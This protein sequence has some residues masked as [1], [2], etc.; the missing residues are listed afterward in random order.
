MTLASGAEA[1]LI[2][3]LVPGVVDAWW[4]TGERYESVGR[5][6]EATPHFTKGGGWLLCFDT[7]GI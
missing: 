5:R 1:Y 6:G 3:A 4:V 2:L 7:P